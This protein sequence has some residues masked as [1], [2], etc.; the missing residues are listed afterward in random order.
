[1]N[2]I[3]HAKKIPA[4]LVQSEWLSREF[5]SLSTCYHSQFYFHVRLSTF[6]FQPPGLAALGHTYFARRCSASDKSSIY[7]LLTDCILAACMV[8]YVPLW[9]VQFFIKVIN[10][11]AN[12]IFGANAFVIC[13]SFQ[14]VAHLGAGPPL[15]YPV[16]AEV[17]GTHN[18]RYGVGKFD[19]IIF[20]DKLHLVASERL[21]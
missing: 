7:V 13:A 6:S 8:C 4:A 2:F 18:I 11:I 20:Y 15:F 10:D 3:L 19:L 14:G 5:Y 21:S 12:I 16:C 17:P 9:A 1:M